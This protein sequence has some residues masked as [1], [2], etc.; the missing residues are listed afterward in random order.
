MST[1]FFLD[2]PGKKTHRL[3]DLLKHLSLFSA[4]HMCS[5]VVRDHRQ[6]QRW[7]NSKRRGISLRCTVLAHACYDADGTHG[8]RMY[9]TTISVCFS[10]HISLPGCMVPKGV[11]SMI[12]RILMSH[13]RG[14]SQATNDALPNEQRAD[15]N[16]CAPRQAPMLS[17]ATVTTST[18]QAAHEYT[19][20]KRVIQQHGLLEKQPLYAARKAG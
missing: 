12:N 16:A 6:A 13:F 19:E 20:L 4:L 8:L 9:L 14:A 3:I 18:P 15:L 1:L 10:P 11:L 5:L 17:S 7:T 2:P